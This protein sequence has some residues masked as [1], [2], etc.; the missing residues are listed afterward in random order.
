[1]DKILFL[2][3]FADQI[4]YLFLMKKILHLSIYFSFL[5]SYS[6]KDNVA[7]GG[8]GSGSGGTVS[9]SIGQV[10]YETYNGSNGNL[11]QGVQQPFEIFVTLI[12]PEFL[13]DLTTITLLP[14]PAVNTVVLSVSDWNTIEGALYNLTDITGKIIEKGNI[15]SKDTSLDVSKLPEAC[16]F[17]NVFQNNKA[18]KSFKLL[19]KTF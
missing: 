7:S 8:E 5:L 6:Q 12:N 10:S 4:Y 11:N 19:K 16:Y 15:N 18:L 1:M 14:N 2:T 3:L 13:S 9:Y 17:L